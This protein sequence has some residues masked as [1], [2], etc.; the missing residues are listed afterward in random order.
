MVVSS[1]F[2]GGFCNSWLLREREMFLV[3][4]L[5]LWTVLLF[6]YLMVDFFAEVHATAQ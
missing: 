4:L 2:G 5:Y 1:E 6:S 3:T